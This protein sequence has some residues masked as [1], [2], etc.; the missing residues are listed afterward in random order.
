VSG[1]GEG[2]TLVELV[3]VLAILAGLVAVAFPGIVRLY[4][5]VRWAFE[6]DDLRRQLLVLPEQVRDS[7]QGGILI[8]TSED[9][10]KRARAL[11]LLKPGIEE[12]PVLRLTLPAGWS[13]SVAKPIYYHFTGVCEGGAVSFTLP[14]MSYT[15]QLTAPLCRP[16][17]ANA[18]AN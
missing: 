7:G 4:A 1:G 11:T 12:W 5:S 16:L 6:Q 15:Y 17:L 10:L 14:P 3:V 9:D 2:F 8:G 18:S 13:M